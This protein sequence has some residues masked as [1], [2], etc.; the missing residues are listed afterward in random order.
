MR[1]K[2]VQVSGAL[3][4]DILTTGRSFDGCSIQEG[5]PVGAVLRG[6]SVVDP[7][8]LGGVPGP[9]YEIELLFEH[10][11][12]PDIDDSTVTPPNIHIIVVRRQEH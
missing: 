8:A 6:V 5:L 12:F 4:V 1:L 9:V 3:V 2:K 11:S 7:V 10:E